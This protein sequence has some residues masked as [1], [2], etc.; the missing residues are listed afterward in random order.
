M[1]SSAVIKGFDVVKDGGARLGQ[2]DEAVMVNELLFEAAPE[3]LD[4]GIVVAIAFAAH[5]GEE[6]VLSQ[7][8]PVSRAG[9][10]TAAIRVEDE[11]TGWPALA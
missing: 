3:G 5:G 8:L 10:L 9:E 6:P 11:W 4:E 1:Q 2:G 7:E